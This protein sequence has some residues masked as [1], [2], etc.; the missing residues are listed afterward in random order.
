MKLYIIFKCSTSRTM[1]P[2]GLRKISHKTDT[3]EQY[4]KGKGL[5]KKT[6]KE[7]KNKLNEIHTEYN[8]ELRR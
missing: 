4:G 5:H 1:G 6:N 3:N 7:I 2:N 8:N